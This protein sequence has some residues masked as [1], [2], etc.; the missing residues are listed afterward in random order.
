MSSAHFIWKLV[1]GEWSEG[2]CLWRGWHT[3]LICSSDILHLRD[4]CRWCCR[5]HLTSIALLS[6]LKGPFILVEKCRVCSLF[7]S[8]TFR[9]WFIPFHFF[10]TYIRNTITRSK[11]GRSHNMQCMLFILLIPTLKVYPKAAA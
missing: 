5:E 10:I 9:L 2:F 7:S 11:S 6:H 3:E 4:F 1:H 8:F